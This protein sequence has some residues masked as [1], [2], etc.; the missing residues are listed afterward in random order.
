M[1]AGANFRDS[2]IKQIKIEG[3]GMEVQNRHTLIHI[4]YSTAW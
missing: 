2:T 4:R 3:N 1:A